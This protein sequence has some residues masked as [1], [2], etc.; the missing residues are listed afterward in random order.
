MTVGIVP[1]GF[2]EAW[3]RRLR[4]DVD[5]LA[6]EARSMARM[7]VR[8]EVCAEFRAL[9]QDAR[10][11]REL[12]EII[13]LAEEPIDLDGPEPP[14]RQ[15]DPELERQLAQLA[16]DDRQLRRDLA[17]VRQILDGPIVPWPKPAPPEP[18]AVAASAAS[19]IPGGRVRAR[20]R[21]TFRR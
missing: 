7:I 10:Y 13:R 5:G 8:P 3:W 4:R 17:H 21:I 9:A 15:W 18:A 12:A 14:P 19:L 2:S 1:P 11:G 20:V 6:A 16:A